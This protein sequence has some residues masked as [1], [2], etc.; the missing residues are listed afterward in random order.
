MFSPLVCEGVGRV[1]G[2]GAAN[3]G[4]TL[5]MQ[6]KRRSSSLE[7]RYL[8]VLCPAYNA[9]KQSSFRRG[10]TTSIPGLTYHA[11]SNRMSARVCESAC[12]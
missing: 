6:Q 12:E 1:G 4:R 3:Q 10:R 2:D 9:L 5:L 7:K 8:C 11:F